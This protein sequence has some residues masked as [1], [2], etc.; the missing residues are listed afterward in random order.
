MSFGAET[1]KTLANLGVNLEVGPDF[2]AETLK[3]VVAISVSKGA[4]ITVDASN[5]GAET[6]KTLAR[7]GGKNLTLKI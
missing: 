1:L 4:H 6:A 5:L 2:G 3:T 7:I